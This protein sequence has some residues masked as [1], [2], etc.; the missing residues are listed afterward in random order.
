LG[1]ILL[2]E[3]L[4]T[5][6]QLD[7]ALELQKREPT[8]ALG[9]LLVKAGAISLKDLVTALSEQLNVPVVSRE[10][11]TLTPAPDQELSKLIPEEFARRHCVL[12][13]ALDLNTLK[14]AFTDPLD[15]VLLDNL[16]KI[17]DCEISR[18]IATKADIEAGI[19]AYYGEGGMLKNVI[20]ATYSSPGITVAREPEERLSLDDL[21]ASAEKPPVVKLTDLLIRQA[22]KQRASDIHIEPFHNKV[23]IRF[24]VDGIL[25][26]IPPPDKSMVLPLISRIKILCK[27]DIAEKRLPQDGSFRAT[28]EN[29]LIDFR[30]STIPTIYG[31][32]VVLRILDRS[33]VA[34]D[35]QSLGFTQEELVTFRKAINKPYGM[36][37]MTGPTGSGK[38]TTLYSALNEI[39]GPTKNII[40]IEDPVEYQLHG[41]NQVQ[42]KPAIGLT[43]ASGL[44]SFLRQDPDIMLV[45]EIR[46]VETAQ[47]CVR[48]AL[49]GHLVF[50]TLHTN[51]APTA[52]SRLIDIGIEPF[53][54]S[55]SLL[56]VVAQRLMR[57]LCSKCKEIYKPLASD[58]P[59]QLK[60]GSGIIGKLYRPKGCEA[61]NFTGY[62][63][64]M[65]VFEMMNI[66]ED[67]EQL[68]LKRASVLNIRA[69]SK[70]AGMSTLEE[71]A[72]KRVALGETSLEEMMRVIL[73]SD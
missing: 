63:G 26:E 31:E 36:I 10:G 7:K 37:L 22:I 43:F 23:I 21:V 53:F 17:T 14:V 27:M 65:A 57:K 58:L 64:R 32:K 13:L 68:I 34:L 3:G 51:D 62:S 48:A 67:I 61:C 49:T 40:T 42:V 39:K 12:P 1:E 18:V 6:E 29:R 16:R 33:A 46:D 56:M 41:I 54:V 2:K 5:Q 20:Q 24:R 72:F 71:G 52:I 45:G 73:S 50:S 25:Q 4:I 30:V 9:D 8:T 47:I 15:V 66:N 19:S 35:L 44:R 59:G 70:R 38:T 28:I 11:G 55:S 60:L 69:A